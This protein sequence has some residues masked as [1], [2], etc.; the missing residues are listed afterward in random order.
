MSEEQKQLLEALIPAIEGIDGRCGHCIHEFCDD[1][2][3][4][5][6]K[7]GASVRFEFVN[8]MDR[9]VEVVNA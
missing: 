6:E 5:L 7:I 3:K 4:E 8:T 9:I 1:A 2:N